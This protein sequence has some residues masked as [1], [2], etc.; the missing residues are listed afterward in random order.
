MAVDPIVFKM[1]RCLLAKHSCLYIKATPKVERKKIPRST[2]EVALLFVTNCDKSGVC[3]LD[4]S[5]SAN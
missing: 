3:D 2:S 5:V 4:S 1:L